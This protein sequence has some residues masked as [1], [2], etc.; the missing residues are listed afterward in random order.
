M[1]VNLIVLFI[2]ISEKNSFIHIITHYILY[3]Y[4]YKHLLNQNF[5]VKKYM[6]ILIIDCICYILFFQESYYLQNDKYNYLKD[7]LFT[8]L[9]LFYI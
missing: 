8:T 5:V 7:I 2:K 3:V 1:R 6:K 4:I 9:R